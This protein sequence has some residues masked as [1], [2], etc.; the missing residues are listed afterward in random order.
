MPQGHNHHMCDVAI[1]MPIHTCGVDV[2]I[3]AAVGSNLI[4]EAVHEGCQST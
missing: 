3:L 1:F 2:G 4:H